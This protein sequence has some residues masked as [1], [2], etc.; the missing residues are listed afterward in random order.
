MALESS[1]RPLTGA[2][3]ET[4]TGVTDDSRRLRH[5][6]PMNTQAE[7]VAARLAAHKAAVANV[8][9]EPLV[10]MAFA[11][12]AAAAAVVARWSALRA[13]PVEPAA[14][15]SEYLY[16]GGVRRQAD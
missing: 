10:E 7:F 9:A 5:N 3:L 12:K 8:S 14:P 16:S 2:C 11:D 15:F 6:A 1:Q 13:T 4:A